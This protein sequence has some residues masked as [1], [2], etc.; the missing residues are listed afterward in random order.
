MKDIKNSPKYK[1]CISVMDKI[2]SGRYV[3]YTDLAKVSDYINWLIKFR[4][5][6]ETEI[7]ALIDRLTIIFEEYSCF[8]G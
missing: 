4:K 5:L 8:I 3:P 2:E 6:P 1:W 7:N